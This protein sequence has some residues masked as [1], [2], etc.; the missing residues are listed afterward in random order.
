MCRNHLLYSHK[1]ICHG[2]EKQAVRSRVVSIR[3]CASTRDTALPTQTAVQS[4]DMPIYKL[5]YFNTRGAAEV[6]RLVLAQAEVEYEDVRLS[7]EEWAEFKPKT[8]YSVMPVLEVDGQLMGGSMPI[9]RYLARQYGLAG[10]SDKTRLILEGAED[11]I[12]DC[13]QKMMTMYFEKDEAKKAE[14]KKAFTETVTPKCFSGL[15]KL[16]ASNNCAEGWFYG[17]TVSYVDFYL[18]H[19]VEYIQFEAP[20]VLD[21]Y[22]ALK[23]LVE[24]V[25]KLPN[26]AKWL[27]ERPQTAY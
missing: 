27:K 13:S 18:M 22:P 3:A 8:P 6:A 14:L 2:H 19:T 4:S 15:E 16:A 26:V 20:N 11:A 7:S 17:P 21:T 10:D 24:N 23:K 25:K 1:I 12:T 5:Y 9:T